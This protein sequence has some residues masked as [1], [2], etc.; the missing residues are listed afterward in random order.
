MNQLKKELR[1]ISKE[2]KALT[3]RAEKALKALDRMESSPSRPR[4][5]RKGEA[6]SVRAKATKTGKGKRLS[7]TGAVLKIINR[8][9]KGVAT[10]TLEAKTGYSK[11]KIWDIVHRAHKEGKIKKLGR[12]VYMKA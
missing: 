3:K 5:G 7:A 9:K 6:A 11:R 12:G 10:A 4:G 1:D 8:R 2:L